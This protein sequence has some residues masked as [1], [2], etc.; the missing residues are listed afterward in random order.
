MAIQ[1]LPYALAALGGYRGYKSAKD[2]GA[3]GL[4][5]ILGAVGGAYSG[6]T[7]GSTG[8]GAFGSP[9]TQA[10]FAATKTGPLNFLNNPLFGGSR[11]PNPSMVGQMLS[12]IHI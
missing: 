4:G 10:Q 11:A 5:R 12:L 9:A 7:L 1:F 8:I 2:S 3:S 6:Y